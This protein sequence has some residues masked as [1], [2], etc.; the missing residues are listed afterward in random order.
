MKKV[1]TIKS[2]IPIY[3]FFHVCKVTYKAGFNEPIFPNVFVVLLSATIQ[4]FSIF[5][6]ILLIVNIL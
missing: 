2:F 4:A 5:G 1:N 6:V 3:G